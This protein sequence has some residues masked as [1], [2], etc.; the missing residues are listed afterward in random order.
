MLSLGGVKAMTVKAMTVKDLISALQQKDPERK[1]ALIL[2]ENGEN[3]IA[4][5]ANISD[6]EHHPNDVSCAIGWTKL[7]CVFL[8]NA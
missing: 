2:W 8:S 3:T 4:S 1:V 7:P 6:I 5:L